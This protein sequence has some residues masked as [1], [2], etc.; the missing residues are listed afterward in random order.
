MHLASGC[1]GAH[2]LYY[3]LTDPRENKEEIMFS[4]KCNTGFFPIAFVMMFSLLLLPPTAFGI[5]L[6]DQGLEQAEQAPIRK[7][8][9]PVIPLD[10]EDPTYI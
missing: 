6:L 8:E 1:S 4:P 10:T 7:G 2:R 5:G 3:Q 9:K